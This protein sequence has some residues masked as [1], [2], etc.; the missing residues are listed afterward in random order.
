MNGSPD[1]FI[2]AQQYHYFALP[3]VSASGRC[4]ARGMALVIAIMAPTN[5]LHR[6]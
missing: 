3:S 2:R 1:Y 5:C 6:Y 4:G